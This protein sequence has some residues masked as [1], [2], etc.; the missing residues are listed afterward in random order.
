MVKTG[1]TLKTAIGLLRIDGVARV[2]L[3]SVSAKNAQLTSDETRQE[4]LVIS[5]HVVAAAFSVLTCAL[6]APIQESGLCCARG[7]QLSR[8]AV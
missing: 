6:R 2:S 5:P 8:P 3:A 7:F 1:G 4:L